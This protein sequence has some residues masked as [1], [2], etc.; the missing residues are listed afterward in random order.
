VTVFELY[1]GRTAD[2]AW[3]KIAADVRG[4]RKFLPQDGRGGGTLEVLHAAVGIEDPRQRWVASRHRPLNLP[5]A[6]AEIVWIMSGRDDARFVKYFN[7]RLPRYTGSEPHL[8]G[9]YGRR[10]RQHLGFDQLVRAYRALAGQPSSRQIVLQIWD[11]R[12][13]MPAENGTPQSS[14]IPCNLLSMLKIRDGK[15]HW[16]QIMRSNDIYKGLPYNFVQFT[17]L[18]EVL[19][20][21]IG[22]EMGGYYHLSDSLHVYQGE[23]LSLVTQS[24]TVSYSF[25]SDVLALPFEQSK[26]A[27]FELG[28]IADEVVDPEKKGDSLQRRVAQSQL[29]ESFLNIARIL[30]ADGL[31]R[32]RFEQEG[33]SL[34]TG[35][36][37]AIY[38]EMYTRWAESRKAADGAAGAKP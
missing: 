10:L 3:L 25:S 24:N 7:P 20:G 21:W 37:N 22:I 27:W 11:G 26:A 14:D 18:Q 19:A 36:T 29:P 31:R 8:H 33:G 34:L 28:Q 16:T 9:A 1:E 38:R 12:I 2:E 17:A 15:L 13:D 32:R 23:E 6:L 30:V 4:G 35:G 5:F